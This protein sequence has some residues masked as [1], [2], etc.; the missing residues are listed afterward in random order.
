LRDKTVYRIMVMD[1][2]TGSL[3]IIRFQ[4]DFLEFRIWRS[5]NS[6]EKL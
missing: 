6:L 1:I 4:I 2:E 5:K 3:R